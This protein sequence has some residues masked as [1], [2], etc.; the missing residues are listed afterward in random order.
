MSR[1]KMQAAFAE[2]MAGSDLEETEVPKWLLRVAFE[3]GYLA[4]ERA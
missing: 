4:G 3:L 2:A 1:D